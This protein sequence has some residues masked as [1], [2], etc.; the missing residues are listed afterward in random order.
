M[1]SIGLQQVSS[2]FAR[3]NATATLEKPVHIRFIKRY[4]SDEIYQSL[5]VIA[6]DG[7]VRIWGAKAERSHQ[8][9]KMVA[10]DG[11]VLF[12]R[13]KYVFAHGVVAETTYNEALAL[14]LWG[15]DH[16]G[17]PW[18]FIFFLRKLV[19]RCREAAG[20]NRILGREETDNWQG[21]TVIYAKDS[22]RFQEYVARELAGAA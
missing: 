2:A 17:L 18:P 9:V 14:Q 21:M 22:P 19:P 12:R 3:A 6:P 1:H 16:Q 11:F 7:L 5:Q 20:F 15:Q 13:S 8:Y 10:R 4:L